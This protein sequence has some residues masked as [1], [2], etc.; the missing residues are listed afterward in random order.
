LVA[1]GLTDPHNEAM[2]FG[3][4]AGMAFFLEAGNGKRIYS[5]LS[6]ALLAAC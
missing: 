1:I 4:I 5:H 6:V 2:M 3:L